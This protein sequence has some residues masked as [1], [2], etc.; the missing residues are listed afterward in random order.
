MAAEKEPDLKGIGVVFL[1][2]EDTVKETEPGKYDAVID[3]YYGT[4][5]AKKRISNENRGVEDIQLGRYAKGEFQLDER[6]KERNRNE[7]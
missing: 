5:E 2:A 1:G 6:S 3:R 7:K 4:S